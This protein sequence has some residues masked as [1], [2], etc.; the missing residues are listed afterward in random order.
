MLT[1]TVHV[2]LVQKEFFQDDVFPETAV[3][4]E[5][6]LSAAAWLS[7]SDSQHHK[8]SLQPKDMTPGTAAHPTRIRLFSESDLSR[9]THKIRP[10]PD[11]SQICM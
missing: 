11:S 2:I 8:I 4:W 5:S 9:K 3:W 10:L 7:G 6:G 1:P